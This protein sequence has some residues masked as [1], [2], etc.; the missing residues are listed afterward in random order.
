M[1]NPPEEVEFWMLVTHGVFGLGALCGPVIVYLFSD[2]SYLCFGLLVA[3]VATVIPF[4]VKIKSPEV[5]GFAPEIHS[6]L[7]KEKKASK[8]I[9]ILLCIL[10]FLYIGM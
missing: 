7:M 5:S 6:Q 8:Q 10:L 3:L 1:V 4:I 9:E 2:Y